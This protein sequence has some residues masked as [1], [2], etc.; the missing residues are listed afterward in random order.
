MLIF[1]Q[2]NQTNLNFHLLIWEPDANLMLFYWSKVHI[3]VHALSFFQLKYHLDSY[4][5]ILLSFLNGNL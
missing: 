4:L 3:C 2:K 5:S 1:S